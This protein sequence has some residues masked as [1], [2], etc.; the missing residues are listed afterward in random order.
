MTRLACNDFMEKK[1]KHE[2]SGFI[3]PFLF[4][5]LNLSAKPF[6]VSVVHIQLKLFIAFDDCY[7]GAYALLH[8][9]QKNIVRM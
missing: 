5:F 4:Q 1:A 9:Q 7:L 8:S 3:C 2:P 6:A